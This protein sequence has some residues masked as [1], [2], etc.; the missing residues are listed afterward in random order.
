MIKKAH[1]VIIQTDHEGRVGEGVA[2]CNKVHIAEPRV[3]A[4]SPRGTH[5][6]PG[7]ANSR[8]HARRP[9]R[10][11]AQAQVWGGHSL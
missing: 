10:A 2:V 7:G 9:R 6:S 4:S 8:G 11:V 3:A 5:P 1:P